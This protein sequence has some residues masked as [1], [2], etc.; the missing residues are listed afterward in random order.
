MPLPR[1]IHRLLGFEHYLKTHPDMVRK[2]LYLQISPSSRETVEAYQTLFG[3][4]GS[5]P[6][7]V[8]VGATK[9]AVPPFLVISA[10]TSAPSF[11]RRP[12][13]MT[14]APAWAKAIAVTLPIPEVPPVRSTI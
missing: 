14:F 4:T 5:V 6:A 9:V 11:S 13:N 8:P 1:Q 7:V 2:V 10:T 3:L 12:V